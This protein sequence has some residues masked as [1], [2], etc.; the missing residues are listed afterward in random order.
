MAIRKE[1]LSS[2]VIMLFGGGFLLYDIRYPLDTLGNPGPGI[3]PLLVGTALVIL[4]AWQ[5]VHDFRKPP[6]P[7]SVE[8][9]SAGVRS[10]KEFL[11]RNRGEATVLLMIAVF[12]LYLFMVK[13]I[14]FFVSNLLFVIIASRLMGARDWKGPIAL[15]A[16]INVFC[17]F[18]FEVWLKLFF[19]RGILF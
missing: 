11:E 9:S 3:F 1:I 8:K 5:L 2:L 18:L 14:G 17:Y 15:S 10:L 13:W 16:G 4:A 19:P 6:V 7:A 12:I